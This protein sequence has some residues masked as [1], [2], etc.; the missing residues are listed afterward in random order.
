MSLNVIKNK[1]LIMAKVVKMR[2]NL[3]RI[4]I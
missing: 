3:I 4:V 1:L 2:Q